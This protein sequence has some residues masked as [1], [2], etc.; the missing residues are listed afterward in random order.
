MLI[1]EFSRIFEGTRQRMVR[2]ATKRFDQVDENQLD[3]LYTEIWIKLERKVQGGTFNTLPLS[4]IEGY[5]YTA[6]KN[7]IYRYLQHK[8]SSLD[9]LDQ[10]MCHL[11]LEAYKLIDTREIDAEIYEMYMLELEKGLL[12]M[13]QRDYLI[14]MGYH[15]ED[16]SQP[17]LARC[18]QISQRTVSTIL[19]R[20]K[21]Y[22]KRPLF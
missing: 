7:S 21:T 15:V 11:T 5:I 8:K 10:A 20:F 18:F 4:R 19:K 1:E 3:H 14:G 12:R 22:F 16:Y 13:P 6:Y 9:A 2:A 17:R